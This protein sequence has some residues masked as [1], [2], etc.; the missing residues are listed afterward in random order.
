MEISVIPISTMMRD[1][2]R[3]RRWRRRCVSQ[4]GRVHFFAMSEKREEVLK[5]PENGG[6]RKTTQAAASSHGNQEEECPLLL[7]TIREYLLICCG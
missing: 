1:A 3:Q 7:A 4:R 6:N 2:P 5:W